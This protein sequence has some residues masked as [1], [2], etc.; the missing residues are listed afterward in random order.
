MGK[1]IGSY[2]PDPSLD[3]T[4]RL[5]GTDEKGETKTYSVESIAAYAQTA[6][7]GRMVIYDGATVGADYEEDFTIG[8]LHNIRLGFTG[9]LTDSDYFPSIYGQLLKNDFPSPA[10]SNFDFRFLSLGLFIEFEVEFVIS[11]RTSG[12]GLINP[13]KDYSFDL[14]ASYPNGDTDARSFTIRTTNQSNGA[15]LFSSVKLRFSTYIKDEA[16]D[17]LIGGGFELFSKDVTTTDVV[18]INNLI[19]RAMI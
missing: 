19:V 14:R 17:L 6:G 4:E 9:P 12:D 13:N 8:S 2:D 1:N 18:T 5:I 11:V 15:T 3:G 16:E 7:T 10:I